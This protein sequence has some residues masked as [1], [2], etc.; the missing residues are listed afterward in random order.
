MPRQ[1][2]SASTGDGRPRKCSLPADRSVP[3]NLA[4]GLTSRIRSARRW[5][6]RRGSRLG[7]RRLEHAVDE[8]GLV[9]AGR[10]VRVDHRGLDVWSRRCDFSAGPATVTGLAGPR[11]LLRRPRDTTLMVAPDPAAILPG[12]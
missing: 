4:D 2:P 6:E 9:G 5:I 12:Y 1:I 7:R 3:N 8:L 10:V 11:A